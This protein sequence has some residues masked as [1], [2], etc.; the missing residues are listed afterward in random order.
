MILREEK[1]ELDGKEILL[2]IANENADDANMLIDYL[3]TVTGETIQ[4]EDI[5]EAISFQEQYFMG[6]LYTL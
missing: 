4:T 5:L 6:E 3:K 2:R 1:Y